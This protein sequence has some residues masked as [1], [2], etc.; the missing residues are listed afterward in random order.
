M[1]ELTENQKKQKFMS[2]MSHLDKL[3]KAKQD[4]NQRISSVDYSVGRLLL[5]EEQ[6]NQYYDE[7]IATRERDTTENSEN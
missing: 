1:E 6:T 3:Y 7:Y 5:T 4:I 2:Y